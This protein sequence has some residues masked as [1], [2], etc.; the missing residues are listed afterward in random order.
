MRERLTALQNGHPK[1]TAHRGGAAYA[2]EN[3][4]AAFENALKMG[5][6][7]VEIDVQIS[8]DGHAVVIHDAKVNRTTNGEGFV[9]ELTLDELR[10]LD[11]GSWFDEKFAGERI[12]LF[13]EIV[14][15]AKGRIGLSIELKYGP[16]PYWYP[17]MV[18][19]V[20]DTLRAHDVLDEVFL[21]SSNHQAIHEVKRREPRL[22][23]AV[24]YHVLLIDPVRLAR[25]AGADILNMHR[26]FVTPEVVALAHAN[27]LGTQTLTNSVEEAAAFTKMGVDFIDS[28]Y[29]DRIQRGVEAAHAGTE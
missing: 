11:A 29:I 7:L 22:M 23:A 16:H 2:P 5:A 27:G 17:E 6:D 18:E 13:D 28:D 14:R 12:L 1:L 21:H 20:V 9:A 24:T 10:A 19:K 25:E 3:T 26:N 15:W 8:K 4:M